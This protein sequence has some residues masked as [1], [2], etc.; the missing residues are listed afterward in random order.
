MESEVKFQPPPAPHPQFHDRVR[1]LDRPFSAD[2]VDWAAR[3]REMA[4]S[5]DRVWGMDLWPTTRPARGLVLHGAFRMPLLAQP[6]LVLLALIACADQSGVAMFHTRRLATFCGVKVTD[7]IVALNTL[8]SKEVG[9]A[10]LWT[11]PDFDQ[12]GVVL[13]R[14][15]ECWNATKPFRLPPFKGTPYHAV[16]GNPPRTD[17]AK[18]AAI[19][20]MVAAVANEKRAV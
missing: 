12:E 10:F 7:L 20:A 9:I 4:A 18:R 8:A 5:D 6:K 2:A 15:P 17:E 13:V 11:S 16:A 1:F 3:F 14:R 19:D